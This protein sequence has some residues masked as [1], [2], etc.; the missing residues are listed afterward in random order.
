MC[1]FIYIYIYSYVYRYIYS[2][3]HSYRYIDI[4]ISPRGTAHRKQNYIGKPG[5][6]L[7]FLLTWLSGFVE[8]YYVKLVSWGFCEQQKK[9][10]KAKLQQCAKFY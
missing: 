6:N 3:R 5:H 4:Y 1:F 9:K 2:Y 10:L 8:A 7:E